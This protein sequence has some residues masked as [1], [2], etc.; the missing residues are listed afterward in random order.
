M[1][2]AI[3]ATDNGT[4]WLTADARMTEWKRKRIFDPGADR[5]LRVV[6]TA[7]RVA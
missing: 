2:Y 7:V 1:G 4:E 6:I 3:D 5:P